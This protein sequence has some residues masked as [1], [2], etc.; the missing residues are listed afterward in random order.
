MLWPFLPPETRPLENFSSYCNYTTFDRFEVKEIGYSGKKITSLVIYNKSLKKT[1]F[2][3]SNS[4]IDEVK[5]NTLKADIESGVVKDEK[6]LFKFF[7][8]KSYE[9]ITET[10]FRDYVA[11]REENDRK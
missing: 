11:K 8:V 7:G 9:E 10:M 2:S 6:A 5:I 1:V 3:M 4:F